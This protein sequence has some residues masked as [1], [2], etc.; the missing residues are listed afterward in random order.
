[1]KLH[2][3]VALALVGWYLMVPPLA[4]TVR[5]GLATDLSSWEVFESFDTAVECRKTRDSL[6][7]RMFLEKKL[8]DDPNTILRRGTTHDQ[9]VYF[10][11]CIASDDLQLR[12]K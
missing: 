1:M 10:A 6:K 3:S 5:E 11:E 9:W 12:D 2:H 8:K 7:S 4:P